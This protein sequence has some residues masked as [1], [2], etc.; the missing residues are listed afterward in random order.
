M[1]DLG[2][3]GGAWSVVGSN[4]PDLARANSG[5][6]AFDEWGHIV[7]TSQTASGEEH[8]FL[9]RG[10]RMTDLGTHGGAD[11]RAT[12]IN[13]W[14]Q[15]VGE[16]QTASGIWHAFLWQHGEMTD[17]GALVT[18]QRSWARDINNHSQIVGLDGFGAV[19]WTIQP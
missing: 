10:G 7:G 13:E 12:A 1:T 19:L 8:A 2:T 9:W 15:V 14:G 17:I 11:S 3:L 16:S 4:E 5:D 18:D 6:R